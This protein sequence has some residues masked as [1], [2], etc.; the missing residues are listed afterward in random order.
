MSLD[1]S[2]KSLK[3]DRRMM[4]MNVAKGELTKEEIKKHLESLPDLAAK[5]EVI[6]LGDDKSR[7]DS[8]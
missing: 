8:H 3:F 6:N 7:Q 1:K 4:E 2:M 5:I